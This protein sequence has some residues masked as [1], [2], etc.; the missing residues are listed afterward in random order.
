[1]KFTKILHIRQK[2]RT[3]KYYFMFPVF[4]FLSNGCIP[5][6]ILRGGGGW[7]V[8]DTEALLMLSMKV[9]AAVST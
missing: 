2:A 3:I 7:G 5:T 9:G 4:S 6:S 1:V 8:V